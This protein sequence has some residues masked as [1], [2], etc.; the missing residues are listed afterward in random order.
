MEFLSMTQSSPTTQVPAPPAT[1]SPAR[2]EVEYDLSALEPWRE[3]AVVLYNDD[4]HDQGEVVRQLMLALECPPAR[5]HGLM[6]EAHNSG[7]ATVAITNRQRAVRIAS[8]LR[9]IE[10]RVSIHQ[11]N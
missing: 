11:V 8:I 2:P 7:R 6:L 1:T 5:A 3:F 10:L 9:Q 4:V